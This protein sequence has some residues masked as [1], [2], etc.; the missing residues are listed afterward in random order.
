MVSEECSKIR[1]II[2]NGETDTR[3]IAKLLYI[4]M[5]GYNVDYG[6]MEC[7]KF[8]ASPSYNQKKIGY[9]GLTQMINESEPMLVMLINTM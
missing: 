9:L 7:I 1:E 3:D 6:I 8:T 5:L 4:Q 2:K